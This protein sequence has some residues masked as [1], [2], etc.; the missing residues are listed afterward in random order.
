MQ[1]TSR[2][3]QQRRQG[4]FAGW[5]TP[6]G[7]C[8][9]PPAGVCTASACSQAH[10]RTTAQATTACVLVLVSPVQVFDSS[11]LRFAV[12]L[13]HSLDE[14]FGLPHKRMASL[15]GV[16]ATEGGWEGGTPRVCGRC[17][18]VGEG[19]GGLWVRSPATLTSLAGRQVLRNQVV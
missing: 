11:L 7:R 19:S 5:A 6:G 2:E 4:C 10:R 8:L 13:T 14:R 16:V 12:G 3:N 9:S 18:G 17:L 1:D 15:V